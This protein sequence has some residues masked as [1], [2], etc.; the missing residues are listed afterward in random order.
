MIFMRK[1]G[2]VSMRTFTR[3]GRPA[4]SGPHGDGGR[5]RDGRLLNRGKMAAKAGQW[6][7]VFFTAAGLISLALLSCSRSLIYLQATS[8]QA[9]GSHTCATII[10]GTFK[11]WGDNAY[12]QLG[13]GD[14]VNRGDKA[15][16][17]GGHL[18][19]ID[20]GAHR[21]VGLSV[22]GGAHTCALLDDQT[23]KCWGDNTYGQLGQGDTAN[24]GDQQGE[25]G[26]NLPAIDL[27]TDSN[28][29]ALLAEAVAAG[30]Y[31]TC[32]LLF[33]K[34]AAVYLVKCWGRN[35]AGQLGQEDTV[36]RGDQP[37]QMGDNLAGIDLG[38]GRTAIDLAAGQS[39]TCALFSDQTIKCWGDNTDGELGQG[40]AVDRGDAPGTMSNN[41]PIIELGLGRTAQTVTAGGSTTC[42]L[43][44]NGSVKCWGNNSNGQLG[45]GDTTNRGDQPGQMGDNLPAIDLGTELTAVVVETALYHTCALL[46]D[47]RVKCWGQNDVGQL[48]Q[49]D[50]EQRGDAPKEMG[51]ALLSIN[52]GTT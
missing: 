2:R 29:K 25:M 38:T 46:S 3:G 50:T 4:G 17:M 9:G 26:D 40:D 51:N 34:T 43:L 18:P 14:T 7:P 23:V 44:D 10:D 52:L 31:H 20:V 27:G 42:A 47:Q 16:E 45:L 41:L 49:G 37:G 24:R 12:G 1:N 8:L 22:L 13:Q 19:A 36:N 28:G 33:D 21:T 39:H 6:A 11:C 48:G 30:A 5:S 35:D 32:A 15:G